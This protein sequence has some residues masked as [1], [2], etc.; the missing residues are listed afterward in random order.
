MILKIF[1]RYGNCKSYLFRNNKAHCFGLALYTSAFGVNWSFFIA[2]LV[3]RFSLSFVWDEDLFWKDWSVSL[4]LPSNTFTR[5]SFLML[6]DRYLSPYLFLKRG[7]RSGDPCDW[8]TSLTV[9]T[10]SSWHVSD[11]CSLGTCFLPLSTF[12]EADIFLLESA[13]NVNVLC[14]GSLSAV[15][16]TDL[17]E[18]SESLFQDAEMSS[19]FKPLML[20]ESS[21]IPSFNLETLSFSIL[22][23]LSLLPLSIFKE[24][25]LAR[26][27]WKECRQITFSDKGM[28]KHGM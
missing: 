1:L 23:S 17:F 2:S 3:G 10:T 4:S 9:L 28:C 19:F 15:L 21:A 16:S 27:S 11:C 14:S 13:G 5:L 22:N 18:L 25:K 8:M 12:A 7:G 24:F 26:N 20:D 6:T